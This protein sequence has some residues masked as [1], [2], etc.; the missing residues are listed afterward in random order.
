MSRGR[1]MDRGRY[2]GARGG[3]SSERLASDDSRWGPP[4]DGCDPRYGRL[5]SGW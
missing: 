5:R 1:E 2:D 3:G 4:S